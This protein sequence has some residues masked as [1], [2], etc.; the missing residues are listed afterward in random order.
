MI[1]FSLKFTLFSLILISLTKRKRAKLIAPNSGIFS[2]EIRNLAQRLHV[3][4]IIP[5]TN[6]MKKVIFYLLFLTGFQPVFGQSQMT[7]PSFTDS[8]QTLKERNF[9]QDTLWVMD[10]GYFYYS[11][12]YDL[13]LTGIYKVLT[14]DSRGNKLTGLSTGNRI[15]GYFENTSLDSVVYFEGTND[16]HYSKTYAWNSEDQKWMDNQYRLYDE[17]SNLIEYYDKGWNLYENKYGTGTRSVRQFENGLLTSVIYYHYLPESGFWEPDEKGMYNYNEYGKDT[18]NLIQRWHS[19]TETWINEYKIRTYYNEKM[20]PGDLIWSEWDTLSQNWVYQGGAHYF[21]NEDNLLNLIVYEAYNEQENQWRFYGK[22]VFSYNTSGQVT[23][24]LYLLLDSGEWVNRRKYV[25]AYEVLQNETTRFEWDT[26]AEKWWPVSRDIYSHNTDS[27]LLIHQTDV[28]DSLTQQL[29][30]L[31]RTVDE[32]DVRRNKTRE[33]NEHWEKSSD[34]WITDYQADYFWS[35]FRPLQ[36]PEYENIELKVYPNPAK[37]S[38]TFSYGLPPGIMQ[39]E[40]EIRNTA[41]QTI[42]IQLLKQAEG[43]VVFDARNMPAGIYIYT[44]KS[45]QS[46]ITGKVVIVE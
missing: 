43:K 27:T 42:A 29:V 33:K 44:L 13:Q 30:T 37:S 23:E 35:P 4:E 12:G 46:A 28:W 5:K 26:I 21:Y 34:T 22:T 38:I 16:V 40:I 20:N 3:I 25:F 10:S 7:I 18:L 2:I 41:G 31:Y 39:G 36:V 15:W 1:M 17:D 6:I 9:Y 32:F 8:I 14:R 45:S 11:I 24:R 19:G